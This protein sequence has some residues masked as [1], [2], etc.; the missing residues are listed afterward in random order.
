M[1]T[2]HPAHGHVSLDRLHQKYSATQQ[3][4]ATAVISATQWL[5]L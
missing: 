4:K 5:M 3:H 1:T 2:N